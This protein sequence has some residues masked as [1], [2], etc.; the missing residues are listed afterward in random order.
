MGFEQSFAKTNYDAYLERPIQ[1]HLAADDTAAFEQ[2]CEAEGVDYD[3]PTAREQF[4]EYVEAGRED[5]AERRAE[6][7]ADA[8]EDRMMEQGEW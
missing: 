5:A 8:L 3:D 1:R 2:F 6:A 4:D 7:R